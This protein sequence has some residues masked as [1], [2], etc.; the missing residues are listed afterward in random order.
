VTT[1]HVNIGRTMI[2]T[3]RKKAARS[4]RGVSGEERR[5]ER[6]KRMLEAGFTLFGT[7]GYPAV[8][9]REV[10][11]HA[12][13]TERYFYESFDNLES[14][15]MSLYDQIH[16]ELKQVTFG[17]LARAPRTPDGM[18]EAS[19]RA[20]FQFV[21]EDPRRGQILLVDST[22]LGERMREQTQGAVKDH[23]DMSR[24]LIVML[25]PNIESE[26]KLDPGYIAQGLVGSL[27]FQFFRWAS[28]GFEKP[29]EDVVRTT[30]VFHRALAAYIVSLQRE[31]P[32][33]ARATSADQSRPD[34]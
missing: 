29:L 7:R 24:S 33:A 17:A 30:M 32:D 8:T 27:V 20:F 15:F 9:V 21:R 1:I 14:L 26:L 16:V 31:L 22:A 11:A 10:C 3:K 25:F 12:K 19:L 13:L 4:F 5:A 28:E 18:A 34:N 2:A 6:R 23:V